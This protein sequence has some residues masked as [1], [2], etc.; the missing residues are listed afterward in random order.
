MRLKIFIFALTIVMS[1]LEVTV[2]NDQSKT[3]SSNLTI[4]NCHEI[5]MEE[6]EQVPIFF[7]CSQYA[8][9]DKYQ[10]S[11]DNDFVALVTLEENG[12]KYPKGTFLIRGIFLGYAE[13]KISPLK[14][15]TDNTSDAQKQ[16]IKVAVTR[17]KSVL[18]SLFI[19]FVTIMMALSYV[20]M[21]CAIDLQVVLAVLKKPIAPS[22]G[23]LCQYLIMPLVCFTFHFH[24]LFMKNSFKPSLEKHF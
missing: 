23:F 12:S 4:Q 22:I 2:A 18:D 10:V 5:R 21:G 9:L 3:A 13:L 6:R 1:K 15:V 20:G 14:N 19:A 16:I 8:T 17:K 24:V 11:V 7:N